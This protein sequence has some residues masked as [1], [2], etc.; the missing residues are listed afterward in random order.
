VSEQI[1]VNPLLV[2]QSSI[3]WFVCHLSFQLLHF[4]A[5]HS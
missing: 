4:S 3:C 5:A 1:K 2:S